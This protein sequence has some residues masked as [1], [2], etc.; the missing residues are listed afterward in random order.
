MNL[1]N[2]VFVGKIAAMDVV[3]NNAVRITLSEVG[4]VKT[5]ASAEIR[6]PGLLEIVKSPNG[7]KPG[8]TVSLQGICVYDERSGHN[9]A[10]VSKNGVSRIAS[11]AAPAP[12][13]ATKPQPAAA[14]T[15]GKPAAP[16]ATASKSLPVP[17]DDD[18]DS[19]IPF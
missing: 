3:P 7:F 2:F 5:K 8:D 12:A 15:T 4:P 1:N 10:V 6:D 13:P 19:D 18:P 11:A 17:D 14:S 16:A 9:V